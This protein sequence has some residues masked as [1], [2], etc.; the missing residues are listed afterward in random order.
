MMTEDLNAFMSTDEFAETVV[1][2]GASVAA[3]FDVSTE[4]LVG[5]VLMVAPSLLL[6]GSAVP[7]VAE[8]TACTVRGQAY[9]VRQ[10]RQE[11]PDGALVR[12]V[13]AKG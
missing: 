11:P 3:L 2:G 5:E 7:A 12:L 13:L 6:P 1:V 4:L 9:R 10:V 8:G